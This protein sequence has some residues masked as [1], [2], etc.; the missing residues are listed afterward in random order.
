[1]N[2]ALQN[3]WA[4]LTANYYNTELTEFWSYTENTI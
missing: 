3:N 2:Y 4:G 1:M